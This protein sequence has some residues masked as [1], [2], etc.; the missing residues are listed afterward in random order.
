M[1]IA[2]IIPP[3]R[4]NRILALLVTASF[5]ASLAFSLLP[6]LRELSEGMRTIILTLSISAIAAILFPIDNDEEE[7]ETHEA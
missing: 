7:G 2:I 5:A 1:F 6:Y 3:A 4:K